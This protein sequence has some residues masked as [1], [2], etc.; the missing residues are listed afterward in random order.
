MNLTKFGAPD[1]TVNFSEPIT[2]THVKWENV[3]KKDNDCFVT[4]PAVVT[5]I[6]GGGFV[7][8]NDKSTRVTSGDIVELSKNETVRF[9]TD[10]DQIEAQNIFQISF[11]MKLHTVS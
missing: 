11:G 8:F 9:A 3:A 2:A 10:W 4:G 6:L 7:I 1:A 5:V